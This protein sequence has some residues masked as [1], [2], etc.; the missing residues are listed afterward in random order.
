MK[1]K[2]NL[3]FSLLIFST[4]FTLLSTSL[5]AQ[6]K[7][8]QPTLENLMPGGNQYLFTDHIYG[9]SWWGDTCLKPGMQEITA[10]NPK[11]G[12][13]SL[14]LTLNDINSILENEGIAEL[15]N[16]YQVSFPW[17]NVKKLLFTRNNKYIVVDW[18]NKTADI[19]QSIA[20]DAENID[21]HTKANNIA[22]T[23]DR[24]L[25]VNNKQISDNPEGTVS[26][27][28]VHRS[29]F[30]I[31]K[32]T[33]WS[34]SGNLLAFYKKDESMVT[35]YPLVNITT[36]ISTTDNVRYP[37]AGMSSHKVEV[38]IYNPQTDK[39]IFL[40]TGDPTDRFFTN[41]SWAPNEE[42]IYLVEVNRDQNHAKLCQFNATNG[43]LIRILYEE[44]HDKY[45]EPQHPIVFLP[46]NDKQFI[47]QSEKD[48]FNHLYL[49]NT[50]GELLRQLTQGEWLVQ[51]IVGFNQKQKEVILTTTTYSPLQS[52]LIAV[53]TKN[54]KT[55]S[56][57]NQQGVHNPIMN[58]TGEY[59][60]DNYSSPNTPRTIDLLTV[61]DKNRV[62]LLSANDPYEGYTQPEITIGTIKAADGQT[63]LYYRLV[64]SKNIDKTKKHPVIVYVYGGPH[65][66]MINAGWNYGARGWDIYM[67]NKGYIVFTLDNRGSDNRGLEFEN[68]T[69]RELGVKECEDQVKGLDFLQSLGYADMNRVGVHGW[70]FGG[71]MTTA[72]MLRYS[73][74]F[75]VGVAGGPVINWEYYEIMYGERYMDTP[76]DNPEG[77]KKTNLCNF[78]SKLKGHLLLIHDDHDST[79]VPQHSLSFIK[80]C[81][82]A[83]TYPDL[84]IYPGHAHNVIGKDRVHLYEKI[85]RY[86]EDYL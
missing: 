18:E 50:D 52:N 86:F 82:D 38:G 20:S 67:A 63:D 68:C 11:N 65:A 23:I 31:R 25:W 21:Y 62:N 72:L 84:F 1:K 57:D 48:G 64:Q 4:T 29:E 26:G 74:L 46:W 85:T 53:S 43:Q 34:P 80:A 51:S 70:S 83:R 75:K 14:F 71:H 3:I 5:M 16:M 60:I 6:D 77:Y 58:S 73:D 45:V 22:Y 54:G 9:L 42:S 7:L 56:I 17:D 13:E 37:M 32:G 59:L 27:Q 47:Y 41:I 33:F 69:F 40:E 35:E 10:I 55:R 28:T 24:N 36:R 15:T 49:F 78:A 79:C 44:S 19:T 39:T 81:I 61:K 66:Q 2:I 12:K 8:K 76:Q 30:G